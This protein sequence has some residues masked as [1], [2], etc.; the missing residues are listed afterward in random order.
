MC[1]APKT[2][3]IPRDVTGDVFEIPDRFL[4]PDDVILT[5]QGGGSAGLLDLGDSA[6]RP[7]EGL[8]LRHGSS[9]I[10]VGLALGDQLE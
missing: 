5:H 4:S 10:D 6:L 9:G 7:G 3:R 1:L 2:G 8:V